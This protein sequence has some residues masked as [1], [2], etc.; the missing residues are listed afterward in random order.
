[1][2]VSEVMGVPPVIIRLLDDHHLVLKPMVTW[3][4]KKD[5]VK[6]GVDEEW[7]GDIFWDLM[8]LQ[9]FDRMGWTWTRDKI[10]HIYTV[11]I[12]YNMS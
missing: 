1:M 11:I 8:R 9:W 3:G 10:W 7:D 12:C 4:F 2:E 6:E 5:G